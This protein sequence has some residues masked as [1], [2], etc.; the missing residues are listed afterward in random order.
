[1]RFAPCPATLAADTALSAASGRPSASLGRDMVEWHDAETRRD[2]QR[3]SVVVDLDGAYR[4]R[5]S[6]HGHQ[7]DC[8]VRLWK[9]QREL[10]AAGGGQ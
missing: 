6:L 8:L 5:I 3:L 10:L 4:L 9:R 7:L 1:M 2:Q